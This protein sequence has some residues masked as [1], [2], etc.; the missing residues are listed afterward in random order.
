MVSK[1]NF[2]TMLILLLILIFMFMF[3]GVLKQEL[4]E[5]GTNSRAEQGVERGELKER[6]DVLNDKLAKEARALSYQ[7]IEKADYEEDD[8]D[9]RVIFLGRDNGSDVAKVVGSWCRYMKRPMITYYTLQGLMEIDTAD[10]PEVIIVDGEA[11]N[12]EK[13]TQS[14]LTL[15]ER[16]ACVIF[17]RTPLPKELKKNDALREMMGIKEVYSED[18]AIDGI[19]LFPEFFVGNEEE[20]MDGPGKENRQDLDLTLPWYVTGEGTKIYMMGLVQDRTWKNESLPSI[21]W[22]HA[23]GEGKVFCIVGDYLTKESGIGFLTACMGEKDSYDIY[24]VINAQNLVLANYG[25]FSDENSE[26]L[27]N[28]YDRRQVPFFRDVVWSS[29]IAMTERSKDKISLLVS[30]QMDYTDDIEPTQNM[31]IY[32]LRLLNEG[33]GEAGVSTKQTSSI[34]L[35][36]KLAKDKVYWQ[37]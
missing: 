9:K 15:T 17:A 26:I 2:F 20:Y 18:I 33:Y 27:E 31:L 14:L 13:E 3:S 25:G 28:L 10:V 5:Y 29:T 34:S 7:R 4:N 12:W 35:S 1:R 37:S 6:Y 36:E 11:V 8:F 32:Y 30:P 22:R 16:G 23:Y 19:R 21:V 24:P